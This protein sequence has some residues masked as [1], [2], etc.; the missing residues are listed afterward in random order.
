MKPVSHQHDAVAVAQARAERRFLTTAVHGAQLQALNLRELHWRM[1][2]K[3]G[4]HAW[5]FQQA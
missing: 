5:A 4:K 1:L 2:H 3:A